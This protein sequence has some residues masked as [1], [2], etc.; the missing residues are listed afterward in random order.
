VFLGM[1][2]LRQKIDRLNTMN[3]LR[4]VLLECK[5]HLQKD[6]RTLPQLHKSDSI[7]AYF[8]YSIFYHLSEY[9]QSH[10][11]HIKDNRTA[12]LVAAHVSLNE[13][14]RVC[15]LF[16]ILTCI[17]PM[18]QVFRKRFDDFPEQE[19]EVYEFRDECCEFLTSIS[20]LNLVEQTRDEWS[21]VAKKISDL[22]AT[23][24]SLSA[25]VPGAS[26]EAVRDV[27]ERFLA[28][29]DACIANSLIAPIRGHLQEVLL[30]DK[31]EQFMRVPDVL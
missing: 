1:G 25:R 27:E 28:C 14:K 20:G 7:K 21:D 19:R 30:T 17:I 22:H 9:C 12:Y 26:A 3:G 4:D 29:R 15:L 18:L 11:L 6:R 13:V 2:K 23:F 8:K 31:T 24:Q 16:R 10:V 5:N